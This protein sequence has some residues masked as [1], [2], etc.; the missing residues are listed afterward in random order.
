MVGGTIWNIVLNLRMK[1]Y[2]NL[3]LH[4]RLHH[5]PIINKSIIFRKQQKK[6][7][8]QNKAMLFDGTRV[9]MPFHEWGH[10][11]TTFILDRN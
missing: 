6:G 10:A 4:T 1:T 9:E 3:M 8:N 5:F 7:T 11:P 2:I